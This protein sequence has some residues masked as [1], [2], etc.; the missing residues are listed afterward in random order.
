MCPATHEDIL[1]FWFGESEPGYDELEQRIILWFEATSDVDAEIGSRFGALVQKA[2]SGGLDDWKA[3]PRGRLA[4]IVL[5]DQFPRN[6]YRGREEAFASDAEAL[7][8]CLEGIELGVDTSLVV[9]ERAFFYMPLQHAEELAIQ[10]KSVKLFS[11]LV[12]ECSEAIR[13]QIGR[14]LASAKS[15]RN[16][17][18]KFGRF[19]HRNHSLGRECTEAEARFLA[20]GMVPFR[21][22]N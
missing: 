8:N 19:P 7:G 17:I 15:H 1:E 3:T 13:P 9:V 21:S 16:V 6:L 20:T 4:L 5:Q 10:E 22:K 12:A 11:H 2:K 18:T 14:F